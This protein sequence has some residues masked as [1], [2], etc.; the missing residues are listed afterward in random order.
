MMGKGGYDDELRRGSRLVRP[1]AYL[2]FENEALDVHVLDLDGDITCRQLPA[3]VV[4][5]LLPI[6]DVRAIDLRDAD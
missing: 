1:P 3:F 4:T 2:T 5:I 6:V